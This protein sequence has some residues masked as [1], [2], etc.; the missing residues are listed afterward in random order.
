MQSKV[1]FFLGCLSR[2]LACRFPGGPSCSS[3][4]LTWRAKKNPGSAILSF[5]YG[6]AAVSIVS[7]LN[8]AI[9]FCSISGLRSPNFASRLG[10]QGSNGLFTKHMYETRE[11][12]GDE[13]SAI[14]WR[15]ITIS[16]CPVRRATD[17]SAD[18][19]AWLDQLIEEA[20]RHC[21]LLKEMKKTASA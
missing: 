8:A 7:P 3:G 14:P 5:S 4:D 11:A 10:Q 19:L 20:Q 21:V 1:V 16:M 6:Y 18:Q 2:R 9:S 17:A 13:F 15:L 12:D